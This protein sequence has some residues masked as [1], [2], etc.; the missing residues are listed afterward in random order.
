MD[1]V[2]EGYD[3]LPEYSRCKI[4]YVLIQGCSLSKAGASRY[5]QSI[6]KA[7]NK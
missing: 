7:P 2:K 4:I 5:Y 1:S 6:K 3:Q